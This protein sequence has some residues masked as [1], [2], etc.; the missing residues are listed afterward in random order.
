[1]IRSAA[2]KAMWVGRTA[3]AVFGLA[4]GLALVFGVTA[5]A[6]A[7]V[8]GDPFKLGERNAIGIVT[9]LTGRVPGANLQIINTSDDSAATALSLNVKDGRAPLK[10]ANPNSGKATN[11]NADKI[12]GL[13]STDIMSGTDEVTPVD[14]VFLDPD[15]TGGS[16]GFSSVLN[17]PG[18][19][20]R[21]ACLQQSSGIEMFLDRTSDVSSVSLW[22]DDGGANPAAKTL[23]SG[24][25]DPIAD[26]DS[27]PV[28]AADHVTWHG[29][30]A[31]GTF[32][33]VLF[34]R[35]EGGNSCHLSGYVLSN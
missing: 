32:T 8:P 18:A 15:G 30:S 5:M 9:K 12:D 4:L 24:S 31:A 6:L 35:Y 1:M 26:S 10:V 28:S 2:G 21:A 27:S 3:A 14:E 16:K 22:R 23:R 29:S 7:A 25:S 13:D 33:A 19:Q 11:L 20:I 34:T 17:V